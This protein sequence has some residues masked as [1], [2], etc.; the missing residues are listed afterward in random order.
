MTCQQLADD[1]EKA[2]S[3]EWTGAIGGHAKVSWAVDVLTRATNVDDK[4]SH[5]GGDHEHEARDHPRSPS[6]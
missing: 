1:Y 3:S 5:P 6:T 2:T 4:E